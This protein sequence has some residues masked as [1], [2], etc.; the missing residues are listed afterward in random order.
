MQVLFDREHSEILVLDFAYT[1]TLRVYEFVAFHPNP[2]N[3][4]Y[5][6][7]KDT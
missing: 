3:I 4:H 2:K 5:E 1:V 7:K 6:V